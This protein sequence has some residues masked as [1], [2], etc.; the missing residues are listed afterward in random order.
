VELN[1]VPAGPWD[2]AI[3]DHAT[4][5]KAN[6]DGSVLQAAATATDTAVIVQTI[7]GPSW[8]D[9]PAFLPYLIRVGGELMRV[10]SVMASVSD[11]F[12]RTVSSGWGT[13]DSGQAWTRSGGTATEFFTTGSTAAHS[14]T[15]VNTSRYSVLPSPSADVTVQVTVSTNVLAAGGPHYVGPVARYVDTNNVY[16]ARI[17][18]AAN[19]G[20]TLTI[21]KR[22]GGTQTD[23]A[24]VTLP[25]THAVNRQFTI[26]FDV[27]GST[28]SARA[29]PAQTIDPGKWQVVVTD[30][31][32]TAAGS[33]GVRSLLSSTNTNTLPVTVAYDDFALDDSQ[34]FTVDRSLNGVSKAHSA[35]EAVNI[36]NPAIT[37]L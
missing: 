3:T 4:F 2:T 7:A 14:V 8:T 23:L 36:A 28:L 9:D 15:S 35:G 16:F 34:R 26:R 20:V 32:L 25:Y 33:I 27:T 30:T 12:T 24:T 18:F 22:V 37:S 10:N 1:C 21:Q 29:W 17:G 6:T 13:A 19:Q 31:S 11:K 5:G